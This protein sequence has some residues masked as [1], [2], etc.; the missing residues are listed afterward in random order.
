MS[1]G[2]LPSG[3]LTFLFTDIEGS[4]KLG[5][6][7]G[8]E[9]YHEVLE[10][11]TRT[12]RGV[13][14]D[15]GIEVRIDGDSLVMAFASAGK[16]VRG[17]AAAQRALT[18]AR[19]PHGATVRVRIGMHTGEGTLGSQD[20]GADYVGTDIV[21]AARIAA[22]AHG[23]QVLLSDATRAVIRDD[24]PGGV[25]IRTLGTFR[26][27]DL[28][29]PE[30]IHQLE[31]Q[32][33]P[34][35][36]PPLR[37]LD[38]RRAQLPPEATTFIG[39]G[40]ELE[41]VA[42]LLAE[43]HLV[44]LTGTGGTG[45]TR[46]ALRIAAR[47][48][49]RFADGAFFVTLAAITDAELLPAGV[50]SALGL[51]EVLGRAPADVVREW[52]AERELLLVLDNLEQIQGAA[53][54]V[55]ALL[56]SSPRVRVLATSRS[57]LRIA[58]EQEFPVP[59]FAVPE[60]G[61][62]LSALQASDAVQLFVDRARL[63]RPDL[64]PSAEDFVV[65]AEIAKRLDG[66]P[67]AIELAAARVRLLPL[68]AIRDRLVHR[69]DALAGGASTAPQRQRSLRETIAWSHDLLDETGKALFQHLS[70]FVG[71]WTI[72]AAQ[73]V[74]AGPGVPDVLVGLD[75]LA[76]QSLIQSSKIDRE[77]R[78]AMLPTIGEFAMERL[79]ASGEA[80]GMRRRH[81]AFFRGLAEDAFARSDTAEATVWF[82]RLEADLDNLRGAIERMT[83]E[84]PD[85]ALGIAA[86]LR[87][88]WLQRNHSAQGLQIL[89]NL[90]EQTVSSQS[91]ELAAAAVTAG[92]IANWL[93]DYAT[94]RRFGE[95][96]VAAYRRL[97][98]RR[99]L[100]DAL[101]TFGFGMIEIDPSM[102]LALTDEGL[103][104]VQDLRDLRAE[105]GMR[106][107]RAT[108]L[109]RLGRAD[110]ARECV[111]RSIERAGAAGDR[112]IALFGTALLARIQ[113]MTGNVPAAI[114][115]YRSI[116]ESSRAIDLRIGIAL[117]LE[118]F[119]DLAIWGR[120]VPR[121]VRLGAAAERLKA[122]LGGGID[123]RMG[124]AMQPLVVGRSQLAPGD[125]EREEAAGNAMDI[126]SAIAEAVATPPPAVVPSM[127]PAPA[128]TN[129]EVT[130]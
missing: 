130:R 85:T 83:A 23:G 11:H 14:S 128:P 22:V 15:G 125:F 19:F 24:L 61:A 77:L 27:K 51:P 12:L 20:A 8:T 25:R 99:A 73:A 18:V 108:A 70:V 114:A 33:L 66:L 16:A 71:G 57:P 37:A 45:K 7:L 47:V 60:R 72:E 9:R 41:A 92:Y 52:L 40:A 39:R 91:R 46:L 2:R 32:G 50:A 36:F 89:V 68:A 17:A 65:I 113:L 82:D 97:G 75:A 117:G 111:E 105:G 93:G 122:E 64:S 90:L 120:D 102:A 42:R 56:G 30:R 94:A 3:T 119:A 112:Y 55:D 78:F 21:R 103:A 101:A 96:S 28:P 84:E 74:A 126:D 123:P 38:V 58:G 4:T 80:A 109:L 44:T 10:V 124:G 104:I 110:D 127:F 31:I 107:V 53:R 79:E 6:A 62:E 98:D 13:F 129:T 106:L 87:Q 118:Y 43:R 54:V 59:P 100:A 48:A 26:L 35:A 121:A 116:L 76:A 63:V 29:T 67:L 5:V 69:L 34:S 95:V 115:T 81:A 88:F 49:D 86:A 1:S